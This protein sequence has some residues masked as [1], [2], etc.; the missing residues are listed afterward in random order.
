MFW[1]T[2]T[3]LV[4]KEVPYALILLDGEAVDHARLDKFGNTA[5]QIWFN[6]NF[7]MKLNR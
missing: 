2:H 3:I 6:I 4:R 5:G 7:S 1:K